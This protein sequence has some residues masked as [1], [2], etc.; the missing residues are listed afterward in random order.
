[1]RVVGL[2]SLATAAAVV[3]GVLLFPGSSPADEVKKAEKDVSQT[4]HAMSEAEEALTRSDRSRKNIILQRDSFYNRYFSI[5]QGAWCNPID[6][7]I[8]QAT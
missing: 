1:M 3:V 5:E 2:G 6:P 8:R 4:E 7:A